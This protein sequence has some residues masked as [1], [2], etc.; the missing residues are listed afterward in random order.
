VLE[1]LHGYLTLAQSLYNGGNACAEAWNFGPGD[2]SERTV[3]W[4]IN[5]LYRRWGARI[6]WQQDQERGPAESTFLKL[7]A[8]KARARLGWQPLLDLSTTLQ[9]IVDWTRQ[10]QSGADTRTITLADIDRFMSR[11]TP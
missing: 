8:S 4:I 3:G 6:E 1:P 5:D 9:W 11:M 2:D 7:D 10:Y